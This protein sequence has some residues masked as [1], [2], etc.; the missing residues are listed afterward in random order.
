MRRRHLLR[1]QLGR[2][3]G[4]PDQARRRSLAGNIGDDIGAPRRCDDLAGGDERVRGL[5][6]GKG[7]V[8]AAWRLP[9][10]VSRRPGTVSSVSPGR[11]I[12]DSGCRQSLPGLAG[13]QRAEDNGTAGRGQ[14]LRR[15][16]GSEGATD[17]NRCG[18][19]Q[20][21]AGPIGS[22]CPANCDT[23]GGG[24][25]LRRL[26]DAERP[27]DADLG[28]RDQGLVGLASAEGTACDRAAGR[29]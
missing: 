12:K 9:P 13:G 26:A 4:L 11:R 16:R 2:R 29:G 28:G 17:T 7:A 8:N 14:R 25:G 1:D 3:V 23:A 19:G 21:L 24:Q 6:G 18:R 15:L 27:V 20:D 22:E 10:T 5:R